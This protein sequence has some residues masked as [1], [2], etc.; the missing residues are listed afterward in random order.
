MIKPSALLLLALLSVMWFFILKDCGGL[1]KITGTPT[2]ELKW[3]N[4]NTA[5]FTLKTATGEKNCQLELWYH[6]NKAFFDSLKADLEQAWQAKKGLILYGHTNWINPKD[7]KSPF[8][9]SKKIFLADRWN[10]L[11]DNA[12]KGNP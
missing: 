8:K 7:E 11:S 5:S 9:R 3:V 2:G 12:T 6:P 1:E 10:F 4:E